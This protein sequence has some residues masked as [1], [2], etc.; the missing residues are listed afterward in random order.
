MKNLILILLF[1][2]LANTSFAQFFYNDI[3]AKKQINLQMTQFKTNNIKTITV[4]KLDKEN[5]TTEDFAVT[6][7]IDAKYKTKFTTNKLS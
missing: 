1:I 3:Y 2:K 5:E 4:K 6:K 7:T